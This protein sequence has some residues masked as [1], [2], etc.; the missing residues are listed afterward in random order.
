MIPPESVH[1]H[2]CSSHHYLL[3]ARGSAHS[4]SDWSLSWVQLSV[5]WLMD[6]L[7][8][9]ICAGRTLR[10]LGPRDCHSWP[11]YRGLTYRAVILLE[12]GSQAPRPAIPPLLSVM[13]PSRDIEL[14][15]CLTGLTP[16]SRLPGTDTLTNWSWYTC[17]WM[18]GSLLW[19]ASL[20]PGGI[21]SRWG[22]DVPTLY[23]DRLCGV[24][25]SLA[26]MLFTGNGSECLWSVFKV[27]NVNE[28]KR[29][30][31]ASFQISSQ[32][33][34]PCLSLQWSHWG[35]PSL[36]SLWWAIGESGEKPS[37]FGAS[38]TFWRFV[39]DRPAFVQLSERKRFSAFL[40]TTNTRHVL[41]FV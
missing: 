28:I 36:F 30:K 26:C 13:L 1:S 11:L 9:F 15:S 10:C 32:R 12:Q 16:A 38:C 2:V 23:I 18:L 22:M 35:V 34:S 19:G 25:I 17:S 3:K 20:L 8:Y 39:S 5:S 33:L 29:E 24:W 21:N 41:I 27:Q 14:P 31:M 7:S 37:E 6:G 40:V 4:S